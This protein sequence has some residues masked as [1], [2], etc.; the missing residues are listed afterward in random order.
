[1]VR[2]IEIFRKYFR[3]FTGSYVIIG[4]TA[5]E[6][7]FEEKGLVF[8]TTKDIDIVLVIEA[9]KPSFVYQ[10][11]EFIKA[12]GYNQKQ[13]EEKERKYYRFSNPTDIN[14][15]KIIELFSKRPDVLKEIDGI[16]LTPI[17]LEDNLTSLSAILLDD[18]YYQ[19]TI[20]TTQLVNDL[21]VA[22]T[23]ALIAL[24]VSAFLDMLQRKESGLSVD[25]NDITK[26]KNDILKLV[27]TL[28]ESSEVDCNEKIKT[29]IDGFITL[30]KT[31]KLDLP[32]MFKKM[33]IEFI[34]VEKLL[35]QL[36]STFKIE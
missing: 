5:C 31:E 1:M 30:I 16:H 32:S 3:E 20:G 23:E 26:H 18:D 19:F 2:G 21:S 36:K 27:A 11:K 9:L 4:G 33:G 34:E 12:G 13:V 10:F 15:P 7:Q 22:S 29:D 35:A 28:T 17:L 6:Q 8:R 14:F 24:K 25:S